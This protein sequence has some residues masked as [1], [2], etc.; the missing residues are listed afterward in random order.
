MFIRRWM[1]RGI[2]APRDS[3]LG[4][5]CQGDK[6]EPA[7]AAQALDRFDRQLILKI[8]DLLLYPAV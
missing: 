7:R 4:R 6:L 5:I 1:F 3:F 8:S 2:G